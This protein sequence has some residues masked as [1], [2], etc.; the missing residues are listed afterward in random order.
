LKDNDIYYYYQKKC[1][2]KAGRGRL[3][4]PNDPKTPAPRKHPKERKID[5][6]L[7][8]NSIINI[9]FVFEHVKVY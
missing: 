2:H 8:L 4:S 5:V 1:M 7:A 6:I 3:K 9:V